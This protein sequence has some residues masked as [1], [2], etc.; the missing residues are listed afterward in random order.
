VVCRR[1]DAQTHAIAGATPGVLRV[2]V[3]LPG[4]LAAMRA[5][6][7]AAGGDC[8]GFVDDDAEPHDR[9]L[10]GVVAHLADPRVGAV[11]GRDIVAPDG[12]RPTSDVGRITSIGKL[13]GNHHLGNG[14]PRDVHVLKAANM[15]FRRAAL[16]LPD[17]LRGAGAQVHF[18]VA[19]SLWA[20]DRGWRLVYDP[21]LV[22]DHFAGPRFDDDARGAQSARA[23]ANAAFNLVLCLGTLRP[24]LRSRRIA[25]GLLAGDKGAPGLLRTARAV[26]QRDATTAARLLPSVVGQVAAYRAL[27]RGDPI[28]AMYVYPTPGVEATWRDSASES[29]Q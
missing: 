23:T 16:A 26:L 3:N 7:R 14:P 29:L 2:E 1:E 5:G 27:R 12:A 13:V 28:L 19:T 11:G 25:Y 9:W 20:A 21:A 24:H 8:I 4:V 6:A 10:E 15:V 18:E 22:V 17:G